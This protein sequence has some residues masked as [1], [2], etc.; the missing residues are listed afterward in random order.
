MF[1]AQIVRELGAR[2][3]MDAAQSLFLTEQLRDIETRVYDAP[4][5][6]FKYQVLVPPQKIAAG[7]REWGYD[8]I[9][10][11]GVAQ[12]L[13]ANGTDYPLV[14]A[15]KVRVTY[16]VKEIALGY[17]YQ[18]SEIL[19]AQMANVPLDS[20]MGEACRRGIES[21]VNETFLG[22]DSVAGYTGLF[23]DANVP[24]ANAA[25]GSWGGA[26]ADQ[27]LSDLNEIARAVFVTTREQATADTLALSPERLAL[28]AST[29][30]AS[31][32]DTTILKFFLAN[33]EYIKTVESASH[34]STAGSGGTQRMVA[35]RRNMDTVAGPIAIPFEQLQPQLRGFSIHVPCWGRI[36]G[37][38]FK[39]PVYAVYRDGI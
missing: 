19:A 27:I 29:P 38:Q 23:N 12:F 14:N 35:Y 20:T 16:P 26:T 9:T 4:I 13:S 24:R 2:L 31:T 32:S 36:G 11:Y 18:Q 30:R 25:V 17:E 5:A 7:A 21:K 34:L 22:G 28:I 8:R 33:Q 1:N 6:P 3:N 39:A 10:A 37:V 15:N